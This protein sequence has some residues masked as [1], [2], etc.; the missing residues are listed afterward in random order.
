MKLSKIEEYNIIVP[1]DLPQETMTMSNMSSF[2]GIRVQLELIGKRKIP[3]YE[4]V[5]RS[6][7]KDAI[8]EISIPSAFRIDELVDFLATKFLQVL[9]EKDPQFLRILNDLFKFDEI[10]R[11]PEK[12][13]DFANVFS[14]F[15]NKIKSYT[16]KALDIWSLYFYISDLPISLFNEFSLLLETDKNFM[17][18]ISKSS[19]RLGQIRYRSL[20]REINKFSSKIKE[21]SNFA[22][23]AKRSYLKLFLFI[24]IQ[25]ASDYE[26]LFK[27]KPLSRGKLKG[28]LY[29][30]LRTEFSENLYEYRRKLESIFPILFKQKIDRNT[31]L[32]WSV[33]S[34]HVR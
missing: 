29:R 16:I 19:K 34:S 2:V 27:V 13:R 10:P 18:Y 32:L 20:D 8:S 4:E 22:I 26:D 21:I 31:E 11:S 6:S 15:N 12:L 5:L 25:N 17:E 23:K 14:K 7:L 33:I 1:R 9:E 3:N 24:Q 30:Q 28:H